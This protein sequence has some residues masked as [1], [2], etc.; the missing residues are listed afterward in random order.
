MIEARVQAEP[1]DVGVELERLRHL[2][3]G[4]IASFVGVVRG[5]GGLSELYL[6][7]HPV[8]TEQR[9]WS[10]AR[11]AGKRWDLLGVVIVHRVGPLQPDEPIVLV[12][13]VARH[14]HPALEACGRLI[15]R[16]KTDAPFWKRETF[17]DGRTA[18]VEPRQTDDAAAAG[19][20]PD[21]G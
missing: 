12:A 21:A 4:G 14:R 8:M 9:L 13:T 5:D 18:W 19:W 6:E 20:L 15:D 3:G 17:A 1:F 16:L 7:H 10:L 2:G 11:A